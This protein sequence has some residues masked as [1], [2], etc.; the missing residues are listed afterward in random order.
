MATKS[1]NLD[2][3]DVL[4]EHRLTDV[5]TRDQIGRTV[6]H[7]A[8]LADTR[9]VVVKLLIREPGLVLTH[10]A[11]ITP[12]MSAL[13]TPGTVSILAHVLTSEQKQYHER[14]KE[15]LLEGK[16]DAKTIPAIDAAIH[17][18]ERLDTLSSIRFPEDIPELAP[19][20]RNH[21][22]SIGAWILDRP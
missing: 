2:L 16:T 4:L 18:L 5:Y 8:V 1:N 14:L 10:T 12:L 21:I 3:L 11:H 20:C 7:C 13:I 17:Y 6:L 19:D 15:Q 9:Q 22:S